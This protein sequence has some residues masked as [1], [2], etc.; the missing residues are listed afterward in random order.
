VRD[1]SV[2]WVA[3]VAAVIAPYE[4]DTPRFSSGRWREVFPAPGFAPLTEQS[5]A[6]A[7]VGPTERVV[8]DRLLS[9]SFVAALDAAARA[10]IADKARQVLAAIGL[11]ETVAFPY[12][13][14]A[15]ATERLS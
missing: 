2:P 8:I 3:A 7:H 14:Q 9:T 11:G 12:R 1:E 5:F 6:H 13:T 4:G 10:E 15:F